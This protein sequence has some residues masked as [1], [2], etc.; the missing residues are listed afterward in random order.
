LLKGLEAN[1]CLEELDWA[2][3]GLGRNP[4]VSEK[5]GMMITLNNHLRH[6]DISHNNI[7]ER[8]CKVISD[9]LNRN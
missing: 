5:M 8:E 1:E 7:N 2:W 4:S 3:N 9:G 6:L